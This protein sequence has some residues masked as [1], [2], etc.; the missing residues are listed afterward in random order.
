MKHKNTACVDCGA[1]IQNY[2]KIKQIVGKAPSPPKVICVVKA[3]AYGHGIETVA[4]TLGEAG[5]SFF[6]VSSEEEADELRRIESKNNRRPDILILGHIDPDNVGD[7]LRDDIICAVVSAENAKLLSEAVALYNEENHTSRR[8]R[9]HVK[10]DTG[11]NRV[12]FAADDERRKET[13]E[14]IIAL[15]HDKNLRLCGIFT[16]FSCADDELMD[17]HMMTACPDGSADG[18][19]AM[20]LR[21]FKAVLAELEKAGVDAGLRHAAN[22]AAILGLPEAYFDAVRAGVILY[23]L[24]PNGALNSK[25]KP[26]MRFDSTVTHLHRVK[27]GD[28]ISY[29]GVYSAESDMLVATVAA[30]YADGFERAFTG[31]SVMI[32]GRMYRQVGRICMD[33]FMV[34]VTPPDGEKC[35]VEVGD[36]VTLFGGDDGAMVNA[37]A[38]LAGTINYEVVCGVSK[39]V[40]RVEI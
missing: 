29:G 16:H 39:R 37:L 20:Q 1:L 22:S 5:C 13:V 6:A 17:G 31:C 9:I 21:R 40:I 36:R 8:L 25:F 30:G 4:K 33:Q 26:I 2:N 15:S 23:G 11:M 12:G 35:A 24:M 32:R 14:E 27:K 3:D 38:N 34:D 19:T 18:H 28:R 10:L 7:M